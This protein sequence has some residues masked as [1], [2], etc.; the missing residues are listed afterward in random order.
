[1]SNLEGEVKRL[2][3]QFVAG[4]VSFPEF[5]APFALL[6]WDMLDE[7]PAARFARDAAML[8]A[9]YTSGHRTEQDLRRE[10]SRLLD[11]VID[12]EVWPRLAIMPL[13]AA[14]GGVPTI[15]SETIPSP[16]RRLARSRARASN[17]VQSI[18]ANA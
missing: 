13:L 2:V 15:L 9:E 7:D 18:A 4:Q 14:A 10:L 11:G 12:V 17:A 3:S 1:M 16:H 8:T 6:T 5:S